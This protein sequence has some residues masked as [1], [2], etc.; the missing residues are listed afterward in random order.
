MIRLFILITLLWTSSVLADES[1]Q[2]AVYDPL[3][4]FESPKQ[5][6]GAK[7]HYPKVALIR[8]LCGEVDIA[9]SIAANGEVSNKK[10]IYSD[11][12]GVFDSEVEK[13]IDSWQFEKK[14]DNKI[15][16]PYQTVV[17]QKFLLGPDDCQPNPS[18]KRD[19]LKPAP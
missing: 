3:P 19:W 6:N 15:A 14:F 17:S 1:K 11:P 5:I 12:H 2:I 8:G 4:F 10:I 7:P 18:F 9:L 16:I 13:V